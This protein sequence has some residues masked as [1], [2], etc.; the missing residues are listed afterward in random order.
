MLNV[1]MPCNYGDDDSLEEYIECLSH[2]LLVESD[3][4][5]TVIAGDF[6]SA[7][8]SRYFP[9]LDSFAKDNSLIMSDMQ[10]LC[11]VFTYMSDDG[12]KSSW[13]D[14]TLCSDIID[15]NI[16]AVAVVQNVIVSD[17]RPLVFRLTSNVNVACGDST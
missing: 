7:P 12:L 6:N 3:A 8:A 5:H 10:R 17:H 1:Y 13:I 14:H 15:K 9:L 2:A 11:D 16:S 4:I